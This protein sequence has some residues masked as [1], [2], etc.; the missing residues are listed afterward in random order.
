MHREILNDL[1]KWKYKSRRKPFFDTYRAKVL[2]KQT[3]AILCFAIAMKYDI[4]SWLI[5]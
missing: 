5:S 2:E 1:E 4:M 3:A